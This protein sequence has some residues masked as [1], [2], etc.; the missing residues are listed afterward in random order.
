[1]GNNEFTR[2]D[3]PGAVVTVLLFL[4]LLGTFL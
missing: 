1:M 2:E 4:L 3:I